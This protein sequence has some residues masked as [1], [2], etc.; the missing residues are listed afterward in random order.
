MITAKIYLDTRSQK[1]DGSFPVKIYVSKNRK[2]FLVKTGLSSI[3]DNWDSDKF[4]SNE[5][6]HRAKN[7]RLRDI[8]NKVEKVIFDVEER[9]ESYSISNER[10]KDIIEKK[11][12]GKL[13]GISFLECLDEFIDTKTKEGTIAVYT[14][15]KSKILEFDQYATFESINKEWLIRFENWLLERDNKINTIGIHLRNIRSVFNYAI[16][17]EYTNIYPFRKYKI[18][19]EETAKRSLSVEELR[20]LMNFDVEEYQERYRDMF[21]LMFYLMGINA[22][23]LFNLPPLKCDKI[24]FHR[25]KTNRLY[26]IKVEPEALKII[27]KYRG[28]GKYMLNILDDY[29]NYKDFLHRMNIGLQKIGDVER[30]GLGGKKHVIPK[31]PGISSYWSRHTWATIAASLDIPKETIAAALGHGG[32]TVTDIYIAFDQRKVDEANRKV[33]DHVFSGK[34]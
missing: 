33:I 23:D 17:N 16:D 29:K 4:T 8:L 26:E 28:Q 6:N 14:H 22:V 34:K 32:N 10:L 13:E 5:P 24:V 19:K 2:Y 18:K 11:I 21:M 12:S 1:K 9:G 31:F 30:K 27:E 15:T 25:A 20:E 3:I 7:V